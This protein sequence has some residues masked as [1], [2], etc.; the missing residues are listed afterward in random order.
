MPAGGE[1]RQ[2]CVQV[3]KGSICFTNAS[4]EDGEA[5]RTEDGMLGTLDPTQSQRA[6]ER[7]IQLEEKENTRKIV[8]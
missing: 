6:Q 8:P 2:L 5:T 3:E 7:I 4:V 1:Q